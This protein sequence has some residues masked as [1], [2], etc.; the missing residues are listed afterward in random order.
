MDEFKDGGLHPGYAFPLWHAALALISRLAGA[1]PAAVVLHG[2]TV[3]LPLS[4]VLAYEAGAVLFRS[5]WAG[6]AA[7]LAQ[8]ALLG[9]APGHG[10]SLVS[11]A[12]ASNASRGLVLPA[13]LTLVFA[14][15]RAPSWAL[16]A[17]VAGA[18]G[19]LTLI[20]PPHVALVVIGLAGF[21]AARVLLARRDLVPLGAALSA[22]LIPA[23]GVVL[24][25]LPIVRETVSHNPGPGEIRRAFANYPTELNVFSLHSYRLKPELFGRPGAVAAAVLALLPLV[26]FARRRLWAAYVLGGMLATFAVALLPFVF[27]HL[28]DAVSISQARRL[29]A[30]SPRAFALAGAALVLARLLRFWVLPVALGAGILLQEYLPGDFGRPYH[31]AHGAPAWLTWFAFAA[32]GAALVAGA[33]GG[34]RLPQLEGA[35]LLAVAA[36]ALFVLPVAVYG[37][38]HW[39]TFSAARPPLPTALVSALR[40]KLPTG[41]VVFSDQQTAY[42][43]AAALPVY[44]NSTP[45]TH[46]SDTRANHPTRRVRDAEHFFRDGGPLSVPRRYGAGWLLVDRT[47]V[48]HK[49]FPL[50]RVYADR[51]YVLYRLK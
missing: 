32:A 13:L 36:V 44:V 41:A 21:L 49:R 2:P 30:F 5:R 33:V 46:S 17:S 7:L 28:A 22:V 1:D 34:R 51:R 39:T 14:Y 40:S 18:A 31:H 24:W 43:L 12:L 10:G 11:L 20:H 25:L 15:V 37:Y 38:S 42:E 27:P 47:R 19:A 50:P 29:I 23:A 9:L 3:L 48:L 26:V 4:F 35:G 8:F 6:L 16:L 45:P